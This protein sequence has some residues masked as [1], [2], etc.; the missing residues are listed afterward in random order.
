MDV[1]A[2]WGR[3][4]PVRQRRAQHPAA[5]R[6]DNC[7]GRGTV[8]F[9]TRSLGWGSHDR[10]S[11]QGPFDQR[12]ANM[13][14][15]TGASSRGLPQ[16]MESLVMKH[17]IPQTMTAVSVLALALAVGGCGSS[18]DKDMGGPT[19]AEMQAA[20]AA[21][22]AAK[23]KECTDAG[24]VVETDGSC[25]SV[26]DQIAAAAAAAAAAATAKACTDGGGRS[27]ADGSCTSAADVAEEVAM[28][29]TA[30][31]GRSN[32]DGSCTIAA[33]L[34]TEAVT[35]AAAT[36]VT[37]IGAGGRGDGRGRRRSRWL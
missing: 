15:A 30:A 20:A 37:A 29:C 9:G 36:K 19:P 1:R 35:A 4:R 27:E 33:S 6:V 16:Q 24:G 18:S 32:A 34:L 13:D 31:G 3:A 26:A 14:L 5:W 22:A 17:L 8:R 11:E 10:A 28:A 12:S 23:A 21:A 7:S 25:T 2:L